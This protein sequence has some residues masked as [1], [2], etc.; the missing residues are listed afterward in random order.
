MAKVKVRNAT[1][2]Y[3]RV[4]FNYDTHMLKNLFLQDQIQEQTY[5][6]TIQKPD[7]ATLQ[8]NSSISF[9]SHPETRTFEVSPTLL[10]P[11]I[12]QQLGRT[13]S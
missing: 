11:K 8:L 12:T 2:R 1:N 13:N 6:K 9:D 7:L 5:S 10:S 4:T 3:E